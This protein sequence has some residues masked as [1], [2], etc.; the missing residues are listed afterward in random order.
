MNFFNRFFKQKSIKIHRLDLGKYSYANKTQQQI[1]HWKKAE[2]FYEKK[3][4]LKAF[5]HFFYYLK[6]DDNQ[7]F[8]L[9]IN[10][11]QINFEF[12]QG[13]KKIY[14]YIDEK[15]IKAW[16]D[17]V[18]YINK[19]D[20]HTLEEFLKLNYK[21]KFS[22]FVKTASS[23]RLIS[24][25]STS[26]THP[27]TLYRTLREIAVTADSIDDILVEKHSNFQEINLAKITP[28]PEQEKKIKISYIRTW[29]KQALS[30]IKK[31]DKKKFAPAIAFILLNTIYKIYYLTSPEGVLLNELKELDQIYHTT[32]KT[33]EEKNR[34]IA[35]RL[36]K[37]YKLSED[38]LTKSLYYVKATFPYLPPTPTKKIIEFAKKEINKSH[39][40]H[41]NGYKYIAGTICEYIIGY[42]N[43]HF[44]LET[45]TNDLFNVFWIVMNYQYFKD[46]GI[47]TNF[48]LNG[49]I[50]YFA[51]HNIIRKITINAKKIYPKFV[52]NTKHL[53][54]T[55]LQD[56][57]SSFIYEFINSKLDET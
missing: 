32:D 2:E 30:Y 35:D 47:Q 57:A 29:I 18:K 56:F 51:I 26:T 17:V 39:W 8:K 9:Q 52:F 24:E 42:A 12:P 46:L 28:L 25:F 20:V 22:K 43:F 45:I 49:K 40:Y 11:K 4:L 3:M 48:I 54:L 31:L 38:Q 53:A 37:I 1:E 10:Q 13:S 55:N 36:T 33:I 16:A 50:N 23:I 27:I 6:D 21:L 5:E 14:G 44:G 19:I 7:D 41:D 15:K 34:I